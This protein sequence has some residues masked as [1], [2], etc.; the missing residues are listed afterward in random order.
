M[1]TTGYNKPYMPRGFRQISKD[2]PTLTINLVK[3]SGCPQVNTSS[4]YPAGSTLG[5]LVLSKYYIRSTCNGL[6]VYSFKTHVWDF[7]W[8]L[9]MNFIHTELDRD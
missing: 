9:H 4:G 1:Y 7:H 5:V 8:T 6:G 3:G 2:I